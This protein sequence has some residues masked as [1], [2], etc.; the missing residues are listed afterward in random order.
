MS[1]KRHAL[2]LFT[3]YPEPGMTKTRLMH[4]Y[5]GNLTAAEAAELYRA[6]VLD[7][8][9]LGLHALVDC[10]RELGDE[11]AF[12]ISSSP[13]GNLPKIKEMFG[14]AFRGTAIE[15]IVDEGSNFDEHFNSCYRQLFDLGYDSV[16][17]I[18]GDLPALTPD[19]IVRS[20]RW[21]SRLA[22]DSKCGS[23]VLAPCQ[24]GGVSL[25][26]ITKEAPV[27]FVGVFYNTFGV[28]ALDALVNIADQKGIPLALFE[29]ISDV[30]LAEDLGHTTSVL[31]AMAYAAKF[32][33]GILVPQRTLG[34]IRKM[35]LIATSMP[36][37]EMDPRKMLDN[38]GSCKVA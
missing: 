17:C 35:G 29:A 32:Q 11:F 28:T 24:A 16:V 6:M 23:M 14:N 36:N 8:A 18:G 7:T 38:E 27:D 13:H 25:V 2:V 22:A 15:Y 37:E 34:F 26:G 5:G 4:E 10:R 12:S 19:L 31:N 21:L 33:E 20:F 30:D 1:K 3:K 9:G